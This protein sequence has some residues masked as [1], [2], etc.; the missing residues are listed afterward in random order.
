MLYKGNEATEA[1]EVK[2]Y[3]P[4]AYK[5]KIKSAEYKEQ[6]KSVNFELETWSESGEKGPKVLDSI[7]IEHD[8]DVVMA[9]SDR[10]LKV[11]IGKPE[12]NEAKDLVGA[13]GYV[14]LRK[15]DK[16]LEPVPFGGY[17]TK[18]KKSATGKTESILT[19]IKAA[20]EF[21]WEDDPYC[22]RRVAKRNNK[23]KRGGEAPTTPE[24]DDDMP[25]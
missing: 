22:V 20:V 15:V 17:F 19:T 9:E 3:P 6:Y 25:F 21:N 8:K 11:M 5:F 1:G 4:G 16:Y 13:S 18:D 2:S 7:T 10:R 12:I 23:A 24:T 14:V